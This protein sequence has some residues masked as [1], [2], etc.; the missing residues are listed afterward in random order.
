MDEGYIEA[1]RK[2]LCYVMQKAVAEPVSRTRTGVSVACPLP[3]LLLLLLL[4]I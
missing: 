4:K 1:L 2:N 3:L